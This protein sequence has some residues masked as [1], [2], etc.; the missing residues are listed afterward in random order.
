MHLYPWISTAKI[1]YIK[2]ILFREKITILIDQNFCGIGLEQ[3]GAA[4]S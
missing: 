3:Y 2:L 1:S 4:V